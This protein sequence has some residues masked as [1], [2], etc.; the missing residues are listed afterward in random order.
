MNFGVPRE[1]RDLERRVGLTPAGVRTLVQA[2]HTVYVERDAGVGAGF[3]DEAYRQAGAEIVYSAAEAYGRADIVAKTTRPAAKEHIHF[4]PGQTIFSFLH[5]PVAS[6]DL[7]EALATRNITAVAYEMIQDVDGSLPV[8][9]PASEIAGRMAPII[10]G[11]LMMS[12]AG[13]GVLLGGVP[14]VAPAVVVILGGGVLGTNAARAFVG[15]GAEVIVL[16]RDVRKLRR[17]DELLAG[18]VTTLFANEYNIRRT[19]VFADVLIGSVSAPGER[20]AIL[21]DEQMVRQMRDGTIIIDF[22]IDNGGCIATSRP[23][24]LRN[25]TYVHENVIHYCVPNVTAAAARSASHAF[26]NAAL[27]YLLAVAEHGMLGVLGREPALIEGL[28]LYQG[29]LVHPK[30]ARALGR[31]VEA[32]VSRGGEA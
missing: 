9:L 6:P 21:V 24:N 2:G 7:Y 26:T 27:P 32:T 13:R 14:G 29:Q 1:I 8:L 15:V 30:V 17:L 22:S 16:D 20:A 11:N 18:S 12:A 31:P 25:P 19:V 5:L 3:H 4:R 10:A 23:T 28:I